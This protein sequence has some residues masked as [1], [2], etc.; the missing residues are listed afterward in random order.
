MAS[1]DKELFF[2][3]FNKEKIIFENQ[4]DI[5]IN[6]KNL[7]GSM[8]LT[9]NYIV[10]INYKKNYLQPLSWSKVQSVFKKKSILSNKVVIIY[11]DTTL[12]L[13]FTTSDPM[14]VIYVLW[15]VKE[16]LRDAQKLEKELKSLRF[17]IECQDRKIEKLENVIDEHENN[18]NDSLNIKKDKNSSNEFTV[19]GYQHDDSLKKTYV[20]TVNDILKSRKR[21]EYKGLRGIELREEI[22]DWGKVYKYWPFQASKVELKKEY[23]NKHNP[24]AIAVY[25]KGVKV[26]Y[27]RPEETGKA[28]EAFKDTKP[29]AEFLSGP[30]KYIDEVEDKIRTV[31]K[32]FLMKI[33]AQ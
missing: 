27:I 9:N 14:N 33:I 32:I 12:E 2:K 25:L 1:R 15:S 22:E 3:R 31:D 28:L 16:N 29:I 17:T 11:D 26:G 5:K 10:L 24:N 6:E 4:A 20:K 18:A 19:V 13:S 8:F 21:T 7:T 23:Q 30:Y